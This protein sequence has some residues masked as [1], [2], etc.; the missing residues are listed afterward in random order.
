MKSQGFF[1]TYWKLVISVIAI[2]KICIQQSH[3][4]YNRKPIIVTSIIQVYLAND[5]ISII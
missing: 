3:P 2:Q 5:F 1:S 4:E